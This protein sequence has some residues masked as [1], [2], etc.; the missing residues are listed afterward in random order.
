MTFHAT[1]CTMSYKNFTHVVKYKN[2]TRNI[3]CSLMTVT[4][5]RTQAGIDC[6]KKT[7]RQTAN[8]SRTILYQEDRHAVTIPR[9]KKGT[10]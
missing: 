7:D 2:N 9:S 8:A 6:I 5:S 3:L 4:E 1:P 10:Q